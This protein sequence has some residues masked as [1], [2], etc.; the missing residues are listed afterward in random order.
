MLIAATRY[1]NRKSL[2]AVVVI[3]PQQ[4]N[5]KYVHRW[6]IHW[7]MHVARCRGSDDRLQLQQM[8]LAEISA[9][10]FLNKSDSVSILYRPTVR[11]QNDSPV[12]LEA[13]FCILRVAQCYSK[14]SFQKQS[15]A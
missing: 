5:A 13:N 1:K 3:R 11:V 2:N 10:K 15:R 8:V 4:I 6:R 7:V 14:V 12:V 9:S